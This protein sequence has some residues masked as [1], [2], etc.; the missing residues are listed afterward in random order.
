MLLSPHVVTEL[1]NT[2]Q[3][4]CGG[5]VSKRPFAYCVLSDQA[6]QEAGR[7]IIAGALSSEAQQAAGALTAAGIAG[8]FWKLYVKSDTPPNRLEVNIDKAT[9]TLTGDLFPSWVLRT[10]STSSSSS[11]TSTSSAS[12]VTPVDDMTTSF[13]STVSTS[14]VSAESCWQY[15]GT[16]PSDIMFENVDDDDDDDA[17]GPS[18]PSVRLRCDA[19]VL[20]KQ[21]REKIDKLGKYDLGAIIWRKPDNWTREEL[22]GILPQE[23]WWFVPTQ[24]KT[25]FQKDQSHPVATLTRKGKRDPNSPS[26]QQDNFP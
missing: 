20:E 26:I 22:M 9:Q 2:S 13:S 1:T 7:E 3:Q 23:Q 12:T 5:K 14:T 6:L 19:Q 21:D 16:N 18:N 25:S 4:A 11:S 24:E 8:V 10:T 15:N 17:E